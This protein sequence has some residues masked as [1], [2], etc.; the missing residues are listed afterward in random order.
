MSVDSLS[1]FVYNIVNNTKE[2]E[3]YDKKISETLLR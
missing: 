1:L 2:V 3:N